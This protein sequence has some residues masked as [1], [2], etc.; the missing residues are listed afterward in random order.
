[1]T[2]LGWLLCSG[3]EVP[4]GDAW[5]SPHER[6]RQAGMRVLKRRLD[7]RAGRWT[8]K[9]ALRAMMAHAEIDAAAHVASADHAVR[10]LLADLAAGER[11]IFT[12]GNYRAQ[13]EAQQREVVSAFRRMEGAG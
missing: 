3:D 11:Y 7:F 8:A 12:H 2:T 10:N 9:Q 6:D 4:D 13:I 5:L 1:M